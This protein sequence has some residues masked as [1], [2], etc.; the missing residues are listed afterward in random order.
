MANI[1]IQQPAKI[2]RNTAADGD[3]LWEKDFKVLY[4]ND[5]KLKNAIQQASQDYTA[6]NGITIDPSTKT[7]SVNAGTGIEATEQG[8]NVNIEGEEGVNVRLDGKTYK[9]SAY[10]SESVINE[11]NGNVADLQRALVNFQDEVEQT[12]VTSAGVTNPNKQ[13]AYSKNGWVELA[14]GHDTA[15]FWRPSVSTA[16]DIS[17]TL[18][19]H[20]TSTP[21]ATQNIKGAPGTNGT[22]GKTPSL[23][24][25]ED[26]AHWQYRYESTEDWQDVPNTPAAS[27]TQGEPGAQGPQ[28]WTPTITA[29]DDPTT[30]AVKVTIDWPVESHI[31]DQVFYIPSGDKGD[32]GDPGSTGSPGNDGY[33]PSVSAADIT[34]DPNGRGKKITFYWPDGPAG[35]SNTEFN[36]YHGY[37]PTMAIRNVTDPQGQHTAGGIEFTINYLDTGT[38][39]IGTIWNGN[40]GTAVVNSEG[41][42]TGNG[43]SQNPVKL[44]SEAVNAIEAV[45]G[46]VDKPDSSFKNMYLVLRTDDNGVVSGWCDYNDKIYSKSECDLR[47]MQKNTDYTLSG[48]GTTNSPLGF[49]TTDLDD[50][51]KY[52]FTTNGWDEIDD[53]VKKTGDTMTGNL[54][55]VID[56]AGNDSAH[57]AIIGAYDTTDDSQGT[58]F[59]IIGATRKKTNNYGTTWLGVA[60][61][62][63]GVLKNVPNA[64]SAAP[65]ASKSTQL[66]FGQADN[67]P[68]L[69]L[70]VQN[71]NSTSAYKGLAATEASYNGMALSGIDSTNNMSGPN[72]MLAKNAEG[73]LVIG[74]AV[75]N[76]QNNLPGTLQPNTYYFVY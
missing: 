15:S 28:G 41:Y 30:S 38:S 11:L 31:S 10:D 65:N 67:L 43:T 57:R 33:T 21:P 35:K 75:Y 62:G 19:E 32:K 46:K 49:D 54:S 64:A 4:E 55:V 61:N 1:D 16:G 23:R 63:D 7:I 47:Y 66:T 48:N 60:S 69:N 68:V 70:S 3:F 50:N 34:D 59:A 26:N 37:S 73:Q 52:A 12:Y 51:K 44:I 25:K 56:E 45:S 18:D 76:C 53:F 17:W 42:V 20:G 71:N 39:A 40:N 14:D 36:I 22:D 8:L 58:S 24:I 5:E 6:G 13:Y 2:S 29:E 9:I 27:G 74:A 72:Y